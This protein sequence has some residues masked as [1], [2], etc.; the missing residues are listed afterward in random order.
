[1]VTDPARRYVRALATGDAEQIARCYHPD[2]RSYGPLAWP[3]EGSGAI[4]ARLA[5]A[6]ARLHGPEIG[7]HDTFADATGERLALRL[8]RRWP[9]GTTRRSAIETRYLRLADGL[10]VE[11]FAGPNTFQ[12]A[13]LELNEWGLD[14]ADT[15][16]DPNPEI[17]AASPT[18]VSGKRP[19]TVAERFVDAFGRNDPGALLALYDQAFTLYSPIAWGLEGRD[20]LAPFVQQFHHGF[21]GL[22]LAL[23]D[24]YASADGTRV[25][26][27]FRMRF[28]NTGTFFGLPP[29]GDHG[30]H[31]EFHSLRLVDGRIVEQVVTDVSYGIP[32]Y[33]LTVWQRPYPAETEDP[34]PR[35]STS[36]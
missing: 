20:P 22:R 32:K 21:P 19:E 3:E 8:V 26:F 17:L 34:A 10:I 23:L 13:D 6:A 30:T 4:A 2:A 28:R 5:G 9:Q 1:M 33:E 18:E 35:V 29:T 15:S 11:E 24:Q 36:A 25:A 7:L 27:R 16:V 12:I 14:P 31:A